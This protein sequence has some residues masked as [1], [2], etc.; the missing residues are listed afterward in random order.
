MKNKALTLIPEYYRKILENYQD[1]LDCF[2]CDNEGICQEHRN[3]MNKCVI[4]L[5]LPC[6]YYT[7]TTIL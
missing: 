7:L 5:E 4:K 1:V 3:K 6:K 2:Y